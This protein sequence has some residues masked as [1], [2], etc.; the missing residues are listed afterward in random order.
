MSGF[1]EGEV[2]LM[3]K[4]DQSK[5]VTAVL[6]EDDYQRLVYWAKRREM[7]VNDYIRYALELAIRRENK[8]F[9]LP[10]LEAAR[11]NQLVDN[12]SVLSLNVANLE[13]TM[14]SGLD[15]LLRMTRGENYL[16]DLDA[17][18]GEV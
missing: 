2:G 1:T 5:R 11:L 12:M 6:N 7:S 3:P 17:E 18:G 13:R 15:A 4:T 14:T 16:A 8:D 9:D 10:T